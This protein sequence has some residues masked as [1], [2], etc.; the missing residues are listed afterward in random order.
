MRLILWRTLLSPL[1]SIRAILELQRSP[2]P[3]S[4][5]TAW[6]RTRLLR[7]PDEM[8]YQLHHRAGPLHA[9]DTTRLSATPTA[10]DPA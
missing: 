1:T 5:D 3:L 10:T 9:P 4:Y 6:R 8:I 7:H 2:T